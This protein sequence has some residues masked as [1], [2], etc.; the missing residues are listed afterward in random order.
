MDAAP[1]PPNENSS[2]EPSNRNLIAWIWWKL[3]EPPLDDGST[4]YF[5][6]LDHYW[7]TD[8]VY[9]P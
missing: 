3:G 2:R 9:R 1:E 4:P 6:S 7:N 5:S 8:L